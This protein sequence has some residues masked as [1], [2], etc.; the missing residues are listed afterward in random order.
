MTAATVAEPSSAQK[1]RGEPRVSVIIL[2]YN[3]CDD[4]RTCLRSV[5]QA[6]VGI[7]DEAVEVFVVDNA[8]SDGSADM[9]ADEFTWAELIRAPRNGGYAYG[10]NLAMRVCRGAYVLLL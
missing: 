4:L 5:Q 10:N 8:S 2:N 7:E 6:K 1:K 9:V 3:T